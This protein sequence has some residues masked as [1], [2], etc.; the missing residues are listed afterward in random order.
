MVQETRVR[1]LVES[2]KRLKKWYLMPP[3]LALTI[4]KYVSR[5]KWS[6]P[7]K[8]VAP[9]PT[10]RCCSYL[11]REL[12]GYSR[13]RN[14]RFQMFVSNTKTYLTHQHYQLQTFWLIVDLG[15]IAMKEYFTLLPSP[16]VYS[17]QRT[18]K[19]WPVYSYLNFRIFFVLASNI[20]QLLS[21][22]PNKTPTI[23]PPAS[24]HENY[25]I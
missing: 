14:I 19:S 11:K 18:Q 15:V 3:C 13:L 5:V 1:S 21:V 9:S 12:S 2:Y 8:G 24:H 10:P 7:G 4:I 22:T 6:N 16:E 25:Q 17:H 20:E 23:R